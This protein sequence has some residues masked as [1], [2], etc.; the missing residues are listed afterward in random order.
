MSLSGKSFHRKTRKK[1]S[2]ILPKTT[3][4]PSEKKIFSATILR[5][6][7]NFLWPHFQ[8]TKFFAASKKF[9]PRSGYLIFL[10]RQRMIRGEKK[11]NF[12]DGF[13]AG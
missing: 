10:P 3:L 1:I 7:A 6:K 12:R 9:P 11:G 13:W 5:Q 2:R 4:S 8:A